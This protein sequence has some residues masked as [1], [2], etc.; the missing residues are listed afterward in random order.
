MTLNDHSS[1]TA[2]QYVRR[3]E[4]LSNAERGLQFDR[5]RE[6]DRLEAFSEL[7]L[8]RMIL[9]AWRHYKLDKHDACDVVH[10][11]FLRHRHFIGSHSGW[12]ADPMRYA[13]RITAWQVSNFRR[14]LRG[15]RNALPD[16]LDRRGSHGAFPLA[17][18]AR[19]E[20]A[21]AA[22]RSRLSAEDRQLLALC[23]QL[24]ERSPQ[25]RLC[26]AALAQALGVSVYRIRQRLQRLTIFLTPLLYEEAE[27]SDP[28]SQVA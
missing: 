12:A 23:E 5:L 7:F 27:S 4:S 17:H 13:C 18:Y 19:C 24:V 22:A 15:T 25:G 3:Y 20:R 26:K 10:D 6:S 9:V 21:Y 28:G 8:D 2:D 16:I 14:G 11:A 1:L